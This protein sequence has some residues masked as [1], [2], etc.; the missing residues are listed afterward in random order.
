MERARAARG[1]TREGPVRRS[2][3][4]EAQEEQMDPA[5]VRKRSPP[6]LWGAPESLGGRSERCREHGVAFAALRLR[7]HRGDSTDPACL[8]AQ[9]RRAVVS[10]SLH[11]ICVRAAVP[12]VTD[13]FQILGHDLVSLAW[14]VRGGPPALL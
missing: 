10:T 4:H 5:Q 7:L 1:G 3:A 6:K 14:L 11:T 2:R 8:E 13:G 12:Q 9:G